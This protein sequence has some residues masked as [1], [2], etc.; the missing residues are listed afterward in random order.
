M[1]IIELPTEKID[2]L[3]HKEVTK[4]LGM[5]FS[6]FKSK[7]VLKLIPREIR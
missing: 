6:S 1:I 2:G 5:S 7:I 3:T 4:F